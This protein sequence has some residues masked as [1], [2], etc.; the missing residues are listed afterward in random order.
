MIGKILG[1]LFL[2]GLV[3]FITVGAFSCFYL[4]GQEPPEIKSAPYAVQT[5]YE[6]KYDV[7]IPARYYY[8]E[9]IEIIDGEAVLS[10]YWTFDGEMYNK[11]SGELQIKPPYKVIRRK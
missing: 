1:W 10:V 4:K 3:V 5:Y 6:D 8:A 11:H 9:N 7:K 2:T